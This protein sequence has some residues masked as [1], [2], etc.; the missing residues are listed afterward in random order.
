MLFFAHSFT[1]R[2]A[3]T[4]G[5]DKDAHGWLQRVVGDMA[6][7]KLRRAVDVRVDE[8]RW[9]TPHTRVG[10]SKEPYTLGS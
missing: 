2:R 9:S 5:E 7:L 10:V 6:K 4:D 1:I 8:R 3:W